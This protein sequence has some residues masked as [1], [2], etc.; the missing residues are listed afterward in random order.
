LEIQNPAKRTSDVE[1]AERLCSVAEQ[2]NRAGEQCE[3]QLDGPR[4]QTRTHYSAIQRSL[5]LPLTRSLAT[6]SAVF[7]LGTPTRYLLPSLS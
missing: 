7:P 5:S 3:G 6:C 1:T 4:V 2:R